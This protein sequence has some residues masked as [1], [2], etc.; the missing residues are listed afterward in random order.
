MRL[1][2][3]ARTLFYVDSSTAL[4]VVGAPDMPLGLFG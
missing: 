2:L 4:N 1:G 3:S